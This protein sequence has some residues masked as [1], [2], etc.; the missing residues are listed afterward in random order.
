MTQP[1]IKVWVLQIG[2][3]LPIDVS[4]KKL[5]TTFLTDKLIERGHSVIWWTSSFNHLRKQWY[6]EDDA[7]FHV[8]K[9]LTIKALKGVGYSKNISFLRLLDHRIIAWKFRRY[10]LEMAQPDIIICSLPSYD[11]AFEAVSY[12]RK[13]GIPILID[14][15][16]QWPDNFLDALPVSIRRLARLALYSEFSM[17][18][19]LLKDADG[20]VS[21][22]NAL[23]EWGLSNAEREKTWRD[24]VFYLGCRQDESSIQPDVNNKLYFLPR[25]KG[26]LVVTFIGTFASYHNPEII[27]DCA[28]I[29]ADK[30]IFFVIAGDGELGDYLKVKAS[31]L[32]NVLF[33]GWLNQLEITTLLKNSD[34]GICPSGHLKNKLFFPNK[35]FAYFSEGLPVLTSFEGD[36]AD[37]IEKLRIGMRYDNIT[38]LVE[39]VTYLYND[40]KS[41]EIMSNNTRKAFKEK[42]DADLI[43]E[44]YADHVAKVAEK[45]ARLK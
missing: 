39:A 29:L 16:D 3:P 4:T 36:M 31:K 5:R 38:G 6:F 42:F 30:K 35:A 11:L 19:R 25:L 20:I 41:L 23:L 21:M 2:E 12:A 7:E 15:R 26:N 14:I 18:N 45:G 24:K 8:D 13:R 43:Y 22:T 33:P 9:N 44:C 1:N 32:S 37:V 10:A 17:L 28:K 34:V 40:R 27:I